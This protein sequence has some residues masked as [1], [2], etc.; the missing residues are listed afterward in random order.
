MGEGSVAGGAGVGAR[1][2]RSRPGKVLSVA[3][4]EGVAAH[5]LGE[6]ALGGPRGDHVLAGGCDVGLDGAVAAEPLAGIGGNSAQFDLVAVC[7]LSVDIIPLVLETVGAD[8]DDVIG[9][10]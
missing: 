9:V 10:A 6:P 8:G 3:G 4:D 2:A 1:S 7:C 5:L